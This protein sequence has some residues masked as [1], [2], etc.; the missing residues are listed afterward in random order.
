MTPWG[1]VGSDLFHCLGQNYLLLVDY[2]SNF[3][4]ICLLKDTHSSTVITHMK[5]VFAPYGIPKT[6]VSDNGPQYS[7][8]QFQQ[9]CKIYD[10]SH[11]PS[12]PEHPKANGLA[13]NTVKIVKNL[14][15]KAS[16]SQED[17]YIALLAYRSTPTADG[18]P[19]P[20]ER[21]FGRKIRNHLPS[22]RPIIC[23]KSIVSKLYQNKMKQKLYYDSQEQLFA[24]D[25]VI[26]KNGQQSAR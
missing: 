5:S 19:S 13:E 14:L 24:F 21:L 23:D 17:P 7:S 9:F 2:Y 8:F 12:S 16:K 26:R 15:K 10:I 11:D 20:A 1:K 22:F 25:N 6:I 3:P 18:L 4:E